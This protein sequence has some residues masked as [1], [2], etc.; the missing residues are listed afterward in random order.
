[1]LNKETCF[2]RYD[3]CSKC[4]SSYIVL[5]SHSFKSYIPNYMLIAPVC[6]NCIDSAIC[7][8]KTSPPHKN[9]IDGIPI[10]VPEIRLWS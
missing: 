1:M 8:E 4:Y 7:K 9:L 6:N 3:I 10:E 2:N 5:Y